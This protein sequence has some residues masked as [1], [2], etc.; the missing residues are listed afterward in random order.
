MLRTPACPLRVACLQEKEK[1]DE[2][3]GRAFATDK[4]FVAALNSAFEHFLNLNARSPEYISLFMDDKLRKGLKVRRQQVLG[5]L[6]VVGVAACWPQPELAAAERQAAQGLKVRRTST[7]GLVL[8][9]DTPQWLPRLPPLNCLGKP[10]SPAY[11][12]CLRMTL[13]WC[14]TR[15]SCSSATCRCGGV[16]STLGRTAQACVA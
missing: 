1:Y 4:L 12:A 10:P 13:R 15:A 3:I 2:L 6:A 14:W 11:R 8:H 16:I 9:V 7:H 5:L